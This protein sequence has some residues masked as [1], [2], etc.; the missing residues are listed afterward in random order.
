MIYDA[1]KIVIMEYALIHF[2]PE[3]HL[4]NQ[5]ILYARDFTGFWHRMMNEAQNSAQAD[6]TPTARHST[7]TANAEC[8]DQ[9]RKRS[10]K[11]TFNIAVREVQGKI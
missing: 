2:Q 1:H 6:Y 3:F 10:H 4:F 8:R 5:Y 11:Q 9:R 7:G